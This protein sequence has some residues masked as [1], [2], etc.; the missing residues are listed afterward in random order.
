MVADIK[1]NDDNCK[2]DT[3][4][5]VIAEQRFKPYELATT[6]SALNFLL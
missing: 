5:L 1:L 4:W 6:N 3:K 2:Y